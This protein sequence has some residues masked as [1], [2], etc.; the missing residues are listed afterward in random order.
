MFIGIPGSSQSPP[1]RGLQKMPHGATSRCIADFPRSDLRS[2]AKY[3][4]AHRS[5]RSYVF[6]TETDLLGAAGTSRSFFFNTP[7][8]KCLGQNETHDEN[9]SDNF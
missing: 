8:I 5:R 6:T 7:D 1:F 3:L 9:E 2:F 4:G